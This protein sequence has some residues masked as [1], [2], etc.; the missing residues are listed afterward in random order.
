MNTVNVRKFVRPILLIIVVCVAL[1]ALKHIW[2]YYNSEPWTRDGRVRGDVIQVSSDV[3]GLVTEVLVQDN[4][5]VK[6]GQV[7]FR[8]D[9]ARQALDVEQAKSDLAKAKAELA[10]AEAELAASKA[11]L[12]KSQANIHLADKNAN[13][14]ANLMNGAISKQEQDQM[15]AARDQSHAEHEQTAAAIEQAKANVTQQKALIE[16]A[17]SNLHLAQLNLKRSAVIAP[18]DGTLSNFELKAGNYVK[19]GQAVAALI[20]REQMY[21]VGYFEETKLDKIYVGAPASVQLMGSS[22]TYKGHVQGVASGIEDRERT[23]TNGLLA[24]VNP[25]FSWVRLAQRVPVKI[26]L[27][28]VPHDQLA[29]VAGRTAT[30]HIIDKK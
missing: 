4:Q 19:V 21:V 25:T 10:G 29:F 14:Y 3:S 12:V 20:D 11:N 23:S 7:L 5:Q 15:F 8:I 28:E 16:V 26:V 30:V 9:V 1:M 18:N 17:N 6:K 2:D 13:R 24:N 27:D 22:E